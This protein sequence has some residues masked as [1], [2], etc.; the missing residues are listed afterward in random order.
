MNFNRIIGEKK[1]NKIENNTITVVNC[2]IS[3]QSTKETKK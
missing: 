1:T 2:S 3:F